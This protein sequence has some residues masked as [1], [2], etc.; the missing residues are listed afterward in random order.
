MDK[1]NFSI[2]ID[3]GGTFTDC[4][5]ITPDGN[6]ICQKVLSSGKLR[7]VLKKWANSSEFTI[8]HSWD[9]QKDIF[10][11][12]KITFPEYP[13]IQATIKSFNPKNN[14]IS[15]KS[16]LPS[17]FDKNELVVELSAREEAPVLGIRMITQTALKENFPRMNVRL[18]STKGTNALLEG[19]GA[20]TALLI[21]KGFKDLLRIGN[22]ARPDIFSKE[23][24]KPAPL[25]EDIIEID[26]R[27]SS[28]GKIE[29]KPDFDEVKKQ[30]IE[31]K[32]KGI[33]SIAI[34]LLNSVR[35]SIHEKEIR[36][37]CYEVGFLN[38]SFSSNLSSMIK[39]L[40]RT[41][42]S[43][44]NAYLSP[45]IH[46]YISGVYDT[47]KTS[48]LKIM[49][50]AG[51]LVDSSSFHP[52]DSLLSGPA[53]GVVGAA[54]SGQKAGFEKLIS[55]DMGGTS[56][57]ASRYNNSFD[58]V[59]EQKVANA[60]IMSPALSIETVAAG[61][62]SICGFDGYKLFTG[63]ESAGANPGPAC[64]G[65]GG[66]LTLTDINLLCGRLLAQN[67]SI[68][69]Y[70]DKAES[71]LQE[72]L[73]EIESATSKIP[74]R[75]KILQD[76]L[77]IANELMAGA[78]QKISVRQGYAPV[79]YALVSFGGAGGLHACDIADLLDMKDIVIPKE[80]GLL[81]AY[82]IGNARMERFSS[83]QFL[84]DLKRIE[85]YIPSFTNKLER[86][87]TLKLE[88]DGIPKSKMGTPKKLLYLRLKGQDSSIEVKWKSNINIAKR[89]KRRYIDLYG[90]WVENR[91]IE[92]DS[93]RVVV[94]EKTK[95]ESTEAINENPYLP[96]T[97]VFSLNNEPAFTAKDLNPGA[98]IKGPAILLDDFSTL[99]IKK[100]WE[101]KLDINHIGILSRKSRYKR[102]STASKQAELELFTNRFKS[103]AENMG[104]MLQ[105]TALS[106]NIKERLD[107]SCALLDAEG[108]LVA[109]APH[110]PV[111]LGGLGICVRKLLKEI[112]FRSGDTLVTNHPGYGGSHL[113][114]VTTISPV[115]VEGKLL[116]FVVNRAHHSELG[117]ISPGS[118][119]PG[120]KNL[121]EEGVVIPPF[122]L[123]RRGK[124]DWEGMRNV[125]LRAAYPTRSIQ[126]NMADLNAALAANMR[127]LES[128][129]DLA[130]QYST[131]KLRY[132]FKELRE[133]ASSRMKKTLN[134]IPDGEYSAIE[135][136]DD[137][138]PL[139]VKIDKKADKISIDF[140][141]SADVHP[142]NMNA[143]EAIVNSV[144]IYTMR[145]L[146]NESIPLNDG[147]MDNVSLNIPTGILNPDFPKD[148]FS[149][150]AVVG[151]NVE[152]SQRLTDT[153]IKAF[154]T[155]AASQ[156]TM[157]NILFG[158]ENFGYYETLAGG[159]GAGE[160]FHGSDAT[161]HH[162]TN[163]RITD[164]EVIEQRFPVRIIR[165][166]IRKGSG[167]E[168]KWNG[169]NGLIREYEFFENINLSILSQRRK[170]GPYGMN[171]GRDGMP[172]K[173]Y[174]IKKDGRNI[175][176]KGIDNLD[177]EKGDRFIIETPGGGG[178]K[179]RGEEVK[180]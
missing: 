22:Q 156:G 139:A 32:K 179:R 161:H 128:V 94:S 131:E 39:L 151:G 52:K 116:A 7:A 83:R 30:L 73:T 49:T 12:Y 99:Y 16:P 163:T 50:S 152:I 103:I 114:D 2:Y 65:A 48:Q 142:A 169:G 107:F 76:F 43:V 165:F 118:M 53:G 26:E 95:A 127:G 24:N 79:E 40:E 98:K 124:A 47:L 28:T 70:P 112:T 119:P 29:K 80:A 105:R 96:E 6:R 117:G 78:I 171:G 145:L 166:E 34:S 21:T 104:A 146:L 89:F 23:I 154:K 14:S 8:D 27:I 9:L 75:N 11:N 31:L 149:C 109:N 126:E 113:P 180:G 144:V 157:N 150:P 141:G 44:V 55:F 67:F 71:K 121:A 102:I 93:I 177:I 87:A 10:K 15:L 88:N 58:Y 153:M 37:I 57:D 62:G 164:P 72:L 138:S 33:K 85:H 20:R 69:V 129:R 38:I 170:S 174:I 140:S 101:Y 111:H 155:M 74:D 17:L 178:W 60:R 167:G 90:H 68:P 41:E 148:P 136:L 36:K 173:Q 25:T 54:I 84:T 18:G 176:L 19:K 77:N 122:F 160:G 56:T 5:A 100:G 135:K 86:V 132:Y 45:V 91:P 51:G 125:F 159:T 158:N 106:V 82:G 147:L 92:V 168:G 130:N 137:G 97:T 46:E 133:Y 120:A 162:M 115:F 42:T 175:P 61:G 123:L 110:I 143:T 108:Y 66:P 13:K 35:N 134:S 172:G 3:T 81:S 4:I 64:Y 1:N 63:P 59:Y